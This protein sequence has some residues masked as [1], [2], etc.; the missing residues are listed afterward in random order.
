[1]EGRHTQIV[2]PVSILTFV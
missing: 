2:L 1:M